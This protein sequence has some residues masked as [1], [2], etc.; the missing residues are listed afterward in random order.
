[1]HSDH[2]W[3][4]RALRLAHTAAAHGEVPIG[5]LLLD[6]QGQL[7]AEGFNQ[8][9]ARH[10]PSAHAEIVVLRAAGEQLQNYRLPGCTLYVT[11]EPCLMCVGAM[12]HAR[13][14]RLVYAAYDPRT[15]A[16]GTAFDALR[17][18]IHNHRLEVC[19]GVMAAQSQALLQDFFRA[20]RQ[21]SARPSA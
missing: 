11:L 13:I 5:A 19:S 2:D 1:M 17:L 9:I 8:S 14:A 15:G 10:D 18:P 16:A 12:I 21:R 20:R 4:T 3:M 7:L 6:S